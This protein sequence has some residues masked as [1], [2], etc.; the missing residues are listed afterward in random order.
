[1]SYASDALIDAQE[2]EIRKLETE[3]AALK[4]AMKELGRLCDDYHSENVELR[5]L[6]RK[7]WFVALSERDA[8]RIHGVDP[9]DGTYIKVLDM[10]MDESRATMRELEIEVE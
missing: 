1:M 8:L 6:A 10:A 3:N 4:G 9:D 2:R 7:N 5:V